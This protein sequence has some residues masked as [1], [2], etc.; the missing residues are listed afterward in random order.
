MVQ[1]IIDKVPYE[2]EI[3]VPTPLGKQPVYPRML[4]LRREVLVPGQEP[5]ATPAPPGDP[6]V[7]PGE[8]LRELPV[9]WLIGSRP[10]GADSA[11]ASP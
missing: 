4:F 9:P 10:P 7:G 8:E 1:K 3:L 11:D 5:A 2:F 6:R